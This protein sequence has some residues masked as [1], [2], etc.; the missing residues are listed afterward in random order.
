[1]ANVISAAREAL[2]P[3]WERLPDEEKLRFLRHANRFWEVH[4]HLMC[5]QVS[6]SFDNAS[7]PAA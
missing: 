7:K 2:P 5:P 6:R 1:M 3:I 4:R